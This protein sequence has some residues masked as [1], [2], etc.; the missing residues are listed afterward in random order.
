MQPAKR[1]TVSI[2]PE[3]D[4][5]ASYEPGE[6]L[7]AFSARVGIPVERLVKLNSNENPY[8]PSPR[9]R[10]A[11]GNYTNYHLYPDV[12]APAL[13]AALEAYTGVPREY[14]VLGNG[15]NDLIHLLFQVFL[16][17]GDGVL[18]CP[19]TFGLYDTATTI[20]GGVVTRVPRGPDFSVD[21]EAIQAAL[22]PETR[23]IVLC[24]PNNPTGNAMPVADMEALL[25]TGRMVVVDEAYM[26][27]TEDAA[28]FSVAHLVPR[29]ENLV[30]LRTFSKW[31]GLAGLRLGYA[32]CPPWIIPHILKIQLPFEVNVAAHMAALETLADLEYV[33]HNVERIIAERARVF[34]LLAAQPFLRVWPSQTNFLLATLTDERLHIRDFRAAL[35]SDGILVRFYHSAD[36]AR[37]CRIS[38]GTPANT[39]VLAHALGK[40]SL[41]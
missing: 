9:V 31:A 11:L 14:L 8:G 36:L 34:D 2:R 17:P 33:R 12:A 40:I 27:F 7:E 41:Q 10:A 3:L 38:I 23:I 26:E 28:R 15:S 1:V 25:G 6:S 24:S 4:R 37:S 20:L 13:R 29:Y 16:N 35:E 39:D 30:V 19:P 21:I 18:L 5:V 32:L 22:R